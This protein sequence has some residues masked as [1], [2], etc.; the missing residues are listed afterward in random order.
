MRTLF[1][2]AGA[3][4]DSQKALLRFSEF[5]ISLWVPRRLVEKLIGQE[6]NKALEKVSLIA[7]L[8]QK[9]G[10]KRF[11]LRIENRFTS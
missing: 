5:G 9:R 1:Q 2:I 8:H 7:A 3:F 10:G 6:M 11:P 4:L